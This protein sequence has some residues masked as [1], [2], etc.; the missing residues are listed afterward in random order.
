MVVEILK[1]CKRHHGDKTEPEAGTDWV[2][3]FDKAE[4]DDRIV[5]DYK[6]LIF[7]IFLILPRRI[8]IIKLKQQI[9]NI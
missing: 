2:I 4:A 1:L 7:S 6:N 5:P 9:L 8:T 3:A